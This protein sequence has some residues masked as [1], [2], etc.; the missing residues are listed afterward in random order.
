MTVGV[1]AGQAAGKPDHRV[2]P[3]IL[4]QLQLDLIYGAVGVAIGV[5]QTAAR[6]DARSRAVH[7]DCTPLQ[8]QRGIED[9]H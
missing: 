8:H 1:I 2:Y 4:A 6:G 3:E 7:L 9:R 5:E